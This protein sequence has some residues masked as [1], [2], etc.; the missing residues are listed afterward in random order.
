MSGWQLD[1]VGKRG[2]G[3]LDTKAG[4]SLR[5]WMSSGFDKSGEVQMRMYSPSSSASSN[6]E[7]PIS[8]VVERSLSMGLDGSSPSPDEASIANVFPDKW[9]DAEVTEW[10]RAG[11]GESKNGSLGALARFG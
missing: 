10:D 8:G 1:A 2:S 6:A 4:N 7:S 9:D 11:V 3:R 5:S